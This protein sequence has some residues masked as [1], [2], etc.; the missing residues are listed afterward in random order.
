MDESSYEYQPSFILGF[1]GC[2]AA[3][4]ESVLSGQRHLKPSEKAY[5]WLG[6]GIYFWEGNV[7]RAREWARDRHEE[8]KI[9][10]PFVLGAIIDLRHCLDLFDRS[11][12]RQVSKAHGWLQEISRLNGT[13]L[14]INGGATPDKAA[15][16]LDCAVINALHELRADEALPAYDSIRAPFLEGAPI[17]E[18]A[19]FRSHAHI[20]ICVRGVACIKGYFRPLTEK[21]SGHA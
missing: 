12:M 18:G 16:R 10:E 11:A 9:E 19:G 20:Q 14:P 17:Y 2:D 5:D 1:H 21:G 8:G 6:H 3:V 15:R 4:G 13:Q 7:L